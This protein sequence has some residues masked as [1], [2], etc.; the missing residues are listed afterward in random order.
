MFPGAKG[1]CR[2]GAA[3][4]LPGDALAGGEELAFY[5]KRRRK[6][7]RWRAGGNR[8]R[9]PPARAEEAARLRP[10]GLRGRASRAA[11]RGLFSSEEPA[12]PPQRPRPRPSSAP[13]R[14]RPR[15]RAGAA[16]PRLSQPLNH[17]LP[18]RSWRARLHPSP[19]HTQC[20]AFS[21]CSINVH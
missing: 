6:L 7:S 18:V 2:G 10:S 5:P 15:P 8:P 20:Q 21:R 19:S 14:P 13:P 1:A 17:S 4:Q 11:G 16:T 3:G 12:P 9:G